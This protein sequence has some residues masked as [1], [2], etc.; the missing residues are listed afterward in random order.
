MKNIDIIHTNKNDRDRFRE[1]CKKAFKPYCGYL[2]ATTYYFNSTNYHLENYKAIHKEQV[3]GFIVLEEDIVDCE[4]CLHIGVLVIDEKFQRKGIGKQLIKFAIDV[5]RKQKHD[6]IIVETYA[7]FKVEKFYRKLGFN[8]LE[9]GT[10]KDT[11]L[12]YI[13]FYKELK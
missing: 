6:S 8:I 5:A 11:K 3:I 13:N 9:K 7:K 4:N 1:L 10:E 2:W 12:K